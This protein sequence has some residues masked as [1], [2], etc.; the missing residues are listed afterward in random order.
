MITIDK[1]ITNQEC[2][3]F[4]NFHKENYSE[5]RFYCNLHR[6]T[7]VI[8][9]MEILGN[10]K[11]KKMYDRL[12][13]FVEKI[14]SKFAVNYFQIV[15]W[16]TGESQSNHV[17][18]DYHFYTSILYLN[19]DFEGGITRV[20]NIMFKPKKGTLI[21]FEGNTINHEVT[22]LE[23]GHRYTMPCWYFLKDEK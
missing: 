1:F 14:N 6:T 13:S 21:S 10:P 16:P 7:E 5:E 8:Q 2:D 12:N 17:D 19:D 11:I 20:N 18:F 23:K 3:E 4:I 9:C 15:H 22:K